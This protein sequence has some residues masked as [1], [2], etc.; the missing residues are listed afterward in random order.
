MVEYS[1]PNTNKPLHLGHLRNIFLG[2][3]VVSLLK[4]VGHK[5]VKTQIINDRGIH[6]CKSM[7]AWIQLGNSET[8]ETSGLKGDHLVGKYYVLFD[9]TYKK[10]VA[11]LVTSGMNEEEAKNNAQILKEAQKML[12]KWEQNDPEVIALWKK[13][14]GWV[15]D[16]FERTYQSLNISFDHLY[17]ESNTYKVG[18]DVV[19]NAL[20]EKKFYK[21][22][23]QSIWCDLSSYKLDDKLLLRSDG[24]SVYMTQDIG[25]AIQRFKD[26][27]PFLV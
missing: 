24:T 11:A 4:S 16:G 19:E 26:Y 21:K 22:E 6:I 12:I 3:A 23:D 14:N 8:P 2:D 13:M 18:K 15:Y 1:S 20:A 10:Q 5:V 25:T 7:V 27:P 9:K 17:Y